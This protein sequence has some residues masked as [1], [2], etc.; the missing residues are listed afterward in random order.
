VKLENILGVLKEVIDQDH[1]ERP[2]TF[3]VEHATPTWVIAS[4]YVVD[5]SSRH[6]NTFCYTIYPISDG[7]ASVQSEIRAKIPNDLKKTPQINE[8]I[9]EGSVAT[10]GSQPRV[11]SRR[12]S[13]RLSGS[14]V[15]QCGDEP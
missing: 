11:I 10:F 7:L 9:I 2:G 13:A 3:L 5:D 14:T 8:A 15:E 6:R 4:D 1:A 12:G